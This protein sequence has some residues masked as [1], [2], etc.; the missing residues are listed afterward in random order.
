MR[1]FS[2]YILIII[3]N[4]VI[5]HPNVT[6][7]AEPI[8]L[9]DCL[10]MALKH[11]DDLKIRQQSIDAEASRLQQ[12]KAQRLPQLTFEG[13][14]LHFSNVMEA[15]IAPQLPG[16]PVQIQPM[17]LQFGAKDNYDTKISLNQP[18]FTGFRLSNSI[19]ATAYQLESAR[20]S[21]QAALNN[22]CFEVKRFY[23]QL[24]N[25]RRI[26]DVTALSEQSVD[27]HL[28]D[29]ENLYAQGM[30]N[31]TDVLNVRIKKSEIELM[32]LQADNRIELLKK[33]L[34]NVM[35]MDV[36]SEL[37]LNADSLATV[38]ISPIEPQQHRPELQGLDFAIQALEHQVQAATGSYYP[39]LALVG[40]YN[41]GKPGLNKLE[42]KWM[43]YWTIGAA[44]QWAIW[45]WGIRKNTRQ[46][47]TLALDQTETNRQK[48]ARAI[49][50]DIQQTL[51]MRD[52]AAKRLTLAR[53]THSLAEEHF[54]LIEN[55]FHQGLVTNTEFLDAETQLR[56]AKIQELQAVTDVQIA[57]ADYERALGT[58]RFPAAQ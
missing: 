2:A 17:H 20:S 30:V 35:G 18:L 53:E 49:E 3:G 39:S 32:I 9:D 58:Y 21:E 8:S 47:A 37:E 22:L 52:E 31:K 54:S 4:L 29:V 19:Q 45:D 16:L 15:T 38:D 40:N 27:S 48:L 26:R 14:Y 13:S 57:N 42:N 6:I 56:T 12:V 33:S 50:L 7:A 34:L 10:T 51:L 24:L 43:G 36:N 44:A 23:Y 46:Q 1:L 11:N 28:R 5:F 41:Y 55:Q 25:A